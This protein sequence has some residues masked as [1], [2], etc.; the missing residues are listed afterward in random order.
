MLSCH[1]DLLSFQ[2][3]P[4]NVGTE[5]LAI[6]AAMPHIGCKPPWPIAATDID[7]ELRGL[8]GAQNVLMVKGW[9]RCVAAMTILRCAYECPKFFE[10]GNRGKL[11]R[12]PCLLLGSHLNP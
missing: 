11:S 9:S 7:P 2:T 12:A 10:A 3:D 1:L 6:A 4:N 5:K 8:V